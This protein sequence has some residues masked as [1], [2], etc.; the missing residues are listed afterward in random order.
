MLVQELSSALGLP[1]H[2]KQMLINAYKFTKLG[3]DFLKTESYI[4]Q[5]Y[6][7][8]MPELRKDINNINP[9]PQEETINGMENVAEAVAALI[10]NLKHTDCL[11]IPENKSFCNLIREITIKQSDI[12]WLIFLENSDKSYF[13]ISVFNETVSV[14][15]AHQAEARYL[16]KSVDDYCKCTAFPYIFIKTLNRR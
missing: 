2:E 7:T 10:N 16:Y 13:N 4:E 15:L 5:L 14:L 9:N 11:F 3:E 12:S 6:N 8:Q 1:S